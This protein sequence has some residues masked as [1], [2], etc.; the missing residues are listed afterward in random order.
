M[1][2]HYVNVSDYRNT[3][4]ASRTI[5]TFGSAI[6]AIILNEEN[7]V[8]L[9]KRKNDNEVNPGTWEIV[10]G[11]LNQNEGFEEAL[12]REVSEEVGLDVAPVAMIGLMHFMRI[13]IEYNGVIFLCHA[14][15]QNVKIQPEEID[16]FR[17]LSLDEAVKLVEPYVEPHLQHVKTLILQA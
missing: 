8:L 16:E 4:S 6:G 3:F 12:L 9:T 10:F 2:K 15:S 7:N 5:G 14:T 13:D 11:R 1:K 17:W